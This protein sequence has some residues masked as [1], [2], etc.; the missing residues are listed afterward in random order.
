MNSGTIK[1]AGWLWGIALAAA[2]CFD[3]LFYDK[4]PGISFFIIT[5]I[6]TGGGLLFAWRE[7]FRPARNSLWLLLPVVF[8][9]AMT[10]VRMEPLTVFVNVMLTL[11][12]MA[13]FALSMRS[14]L[15]PQFSLSDDA[16]RLI[17]LL[18]GMVWRPV[19]ATFVQ[20]EK[21]PAPEAG[22]ESA[23]L[24][25]AK[26][27]N[28]LWPVLRGVALALPI[29]L[30][31]G[32]LLAS[33]DPIFKEQVRSLLTWFDI[34]RLGEYIFRGVYICFVAYALAGV[35]LHSLHTSA[36]TKLIGLDKPWL[37]PFLGWIEAVIV[38]GAVDLLFALFVGVQVRYF[39]GGQ[40]NIHIE[41]YTYA[42]YAR[43]GFGELIIVAF[44]SLMLLFSLNTITR[45]ES[46][47]SRRTFSGLS[48]GLVA[49]VG[50]ILVS[51]FMRLNLYETVYGFTRMRTY[52]HIFMIWVGVL[53]VV[54]AGLEVTRRQRAFG[55]ALLLVC[56]GFGLTLNLVSVDNLIVQQNINRTLAGNAEGLSVQQDG[57]GSRNGDGL[58]ENYL[59]ELS[60]DAIPLMVNFYEGG[61]L[62]AAAQDKLGLALACMKLNRTA[63]DQ[64]PWPSF[65]LARL[66]AD[67]AL[68]RIA[69]GLD[70]AYPPAKADALS[71]KHNGKL[72][73]CYYSYDD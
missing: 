56:L 30:V 54:V 7:G 23:A 43:Q 35:Y 42:T 41:G 38:L 6:F 29:L 11:G 10:F 15:W 27:A 66:Q 12:C 57:S 18:V 17:L 33:A 28:L 73:H 34:K 58:D 44:L 69:A 3:Q 39:F 59:M 22:A 25:P 67:S 21:A 55:L 16:A 72:I 5:L 50:V 31:L 19:D 60:D 49:L 68:A 45:R 65:H 36:D 37:P 71:V 47:A 51:A 14:G 4:T 62:P 26:R 48:L 70:E 2:W 64:M 46:A 13:L 24:V 40:T 1:N 63:S 20:K 52:P 9:S 8:F 32:G 61:N 53:L